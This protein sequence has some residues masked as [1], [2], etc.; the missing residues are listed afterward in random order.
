MKSFVISLKSAEDRRAHIKEQFGNKDIPFYFFDAIEP[1]Q[2]DKVAIDLSISISGSSLSYGEIGCL[3]S[4]VTLWKKAIDENLEYIGIFEDDIYLGENVKKFICNNKWIRKE[5]DIIKIE[6]NSKFNYLSLIDKHTLSDNR[7]ISKLLNPNFGT[8]GYMLSNKGACNLL[9]FIQNE[10]LI[11]HIDQIMFKKYL[12]KGDLP[13]YQMNP[14]LCVQE[15][16]LYPDNVTFKSSL[17]WRNSYKDKKLSFFDK[18]KREIARFFFQICQ[19]PFKV[20][21]KYK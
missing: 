2:V 15:Y 10:V 20:K 13:I 8:A 18:I 14:A 6:K 1:N 7:M 11:D 5:W 12:K 21:I 19:F 16:I 9:R 3:L 4:H 17:I